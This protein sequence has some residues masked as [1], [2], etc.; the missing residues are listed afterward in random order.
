MGPKTDRVV[1]V[2]LATVLAIGAPVVAA[3]QRPAHGQAVRR[4]SPPDPD[5]AKL[6]S[7]QAAA[8][9]KFRV[10]ETTRFR[11]LHIVRTR[12]GERDM[13]C[14]EVDGENAYGGRTGWIPFGAEMI[15]RPGGVVEAIV[16]TAREMDRDIIA[17]Q[18]AVRPSTR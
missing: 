9:A 14:G 10:P 4:G 1:F 3:A 17:A 2:A 11:D 15:P 12:S 8:A 13:L 18:C 16:F 5:A 7:Y 6:A